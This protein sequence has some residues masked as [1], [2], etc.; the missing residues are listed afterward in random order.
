LHAD[1][2]HALHAGQRLELF[3]QNGAVPI[4]GVAR[5]PLPGD[6][7]AEA[8]DGGE[9]KEPRSPEASSYVMEAEHWLGVAAAHL[10]DEKA[11]RGHFAEALL[12]GEA[13]IKSTVDPKADYKGDM[14]DS[15][16]AY[17]DALLR[18]GK[19]AEAEK[20]YA[21]SL[22]YLQAR[23][24]A[25]PDDIKQQPLLALAHER[26]GAALG[27]GPDAEQRYREALRLRKALWQIEPTNLVREAAYLLALA[28]C[29]QCD[30]AA[31]G[32]AKLLPRAGNKTV[33]LLV[34]ARCYAACAAGGGPRKGE[35]SE[36]AVAALKAVDARKDYQDAFALETDLDLAAVRAAP[37]FKAL[38]EEIKGR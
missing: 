32:A 35:Y 37:A 38:V 18:F 23:I 12:R 21:E 30:E 17:G 26:L 33:L 9:L 1:E 3:Q 7:D 5:A 16:G 13:L 24:A 34:V 36:R 31:A 27:K 20:H 4:P 14:A 6:A 25:V 10:G 15:H 22:R 2:A 28:R 11:A 29:G 8:A 19:A